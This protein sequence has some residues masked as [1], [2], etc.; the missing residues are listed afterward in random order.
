MCFLYFFY[1]FAFVCFY[2]ILD[3]KDVSGKIELEKMENQA[4][5]SH[6]STKDPCPTWSGRVS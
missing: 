4:F 2:L 6:P 1:L 3:N 5:E